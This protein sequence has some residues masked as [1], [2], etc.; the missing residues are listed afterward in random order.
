[1]LIQLPNSRYFELP[2][3]IW[4]HSLNAKEPWNENLG[5]FLS[6]KVFIER[7]VRIRMRDFDWFFKP[8]TKYNNKTIADPKLYSQIRNIVDGKF[9]PD[10][11]EALR[12]Y[13]SI[14]GKDG[15]VDAVKKMIPGATV[16]ACFNKTRSKKE[17]HQ[18]N[19]MIALDIDGVDTEHTIKKLKSLD[20]CFW[21]SKSITGTGVYALVPVSTDNLIGHFEAINLLMQKNGIGLDPLKD[22]TRLRYWS[23]PDDVIINENVKPFEDVYEV[24]D[25]VRINRGSKENPIQPLGATTNYDTGEYAKACHK[26]GLKNAAKNLKLNEGDI[27]DHLHTFLQYY[28]WAF[29][30]YGLS[31]S[32]AVQWSWNNFFKD[33][34]Y[35]I[36]K[37]HDVDRILQDFTG[38]YR[39]YQNQHHLFDFDKQKE[40]SLCRENYDM[41]LTLPVGEKLSSLHLPIL[42]T[43]NEL[44]EL[45][46]GKD[47]KGWN[48][49][50]LDSPTNSGKTSTFTRY[51]LKQKIKG[52]IVVPTQGALEQIHADYPEAKLFYEKSKEIS[53]ND[54]LICTTYASFEKLYKQINIYDRFLVVDEFHNVV[55]STSK[56]YRN[57]ELN[58]ILDRIHKFQFVVLMTG[59]NLKCH[60]PIL[61]SFKKL[62]VR[63]EKDTE[64]NLKIVYHDSSN[65][66]NTIMKKV[67]SYAGLQVIYLDNKSASGSL[68]KLIQSLKKQGYS[69][70]EIQLANAD[71]KSDAKYQNMILTGRVEAGL[72]IIIATKIFVEALNLYDQV[73]AFHILSP[74]HGAYMQQL[75]TRPRN[76][77]QCDV[78]LYWHANSLEDRD[79]SY[80]FD[81]ERYYQGQINWAANLIKA[82]EDTEW[83]DIHR[84]TFGG[85]EVVRKKRVTF[86]TNDSGLSPLH[87]HGTTIVLECDYLNCDF[88]TQEQQVQLY[89]HNPNQLYE[90]LKQYNWV[91]LGEEVSRVNKD[92]IDKSE[93]KARKKERAESID[94]FIKQLVSRGALDNLVVLS[95]KSYGS[96][97]W[98]IDIRKKYAYLGHLVKEENANELIT[99]AVDKRAYEIIIK[100]IRI[101]Q[102]LLFSQGDLRQFANVIFD[103]FP[104]NS[105]WSSDEIL[106]AITSIH[107]NTIPEFIRR[108]G[109]TSRT[110]AT[111]VLNLFVETKRTKKPEPGAIAPKGRKTKYVNALKIVSHHP[112]RNAK[113]EA[114]EPF[115]SKDNKFESSLDKR[116]IA[117]YKTRLWSTPTEAE[118][119]ESQKDSHDIFQLPNIY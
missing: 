88:N 70:S 16:S 66:W 12:N 47:W 53:F 20:I 86:Q 27:G 7:N 56:G 48:K 107:R 100:Q 112:L 76:N 72:K 55:L 24:P 94:C 81:Q 14:H 35:I 13:V 46:E 80:W 101:R 63:Y 73:E 41:E 9:I 85:A 113:G 54:V 60:H 50:L 83:D 105:I 110:M 77:K 89:S 75:V 52:L 23:P 11:V 1:M 98:Q 103:T 96:A 62:K 108:N 71:Q 68:G 67:S 58:V 21:I 116:L 33:H 42:F 95:E 31:L 87:E 40:A 49:Y 6:G 91:V 102:A 34:P 84:E 17:P 44:N 117:N 74:I 93:L 18:V 45:Y 118:Y 15:V 65:H 92:K 38:F 97:E 57:R 119:L 32:Y 28:H 36:S 79:S 114:I 2:V 43:E 69:E 82:Y 106:K 59:T 90:Y 78:Y 64:K 39:S 26:K 30:H 61:N 8:N 3:S 19:K 99:Q 115:S 109:I 4:S 22:V 10:I 111:Q 51:F 29:N 5:D 104:L 37:S 25:E